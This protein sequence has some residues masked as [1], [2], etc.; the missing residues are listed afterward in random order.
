MSVDALM[1]RI[2][3]KR[4]E[5]DRLAKELETSL[6]I[7][8]IFPDIFD[9]SSTV[10]LERRGMQFGSRGFDGIYESWL[11][12]DKG[13]I[14]NLTKEQLIAIEPDSIIHPDHK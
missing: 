13:K 7:R 10:S 4:K 2:R 3:E 12:S 6:R 8:D 9:E 11:V 5:V 1:G 14:Y